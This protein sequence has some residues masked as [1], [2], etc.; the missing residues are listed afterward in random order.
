M[1]EIA[2]YYAA[3]GIIHSKYKPVSE[4]FKDYIIL[5]KSNGYQSLHTT[6][7]GPEGSVEIQIRTQEMQHFGEFGFAAH[8][9]YKGGVKRK[10]VGE[11][12]WLQTIIQN[13]DEN[14]EP[15][16]FLQTLKLDLYVDEV[17]VFT[18]KV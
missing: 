4:R 18:P 6:V 17:F 14:L 16:D 9:H 1:N 3:L 15:V 7:L 11:L 13:Q 8:W 10:H 12:N 2:D 5:P